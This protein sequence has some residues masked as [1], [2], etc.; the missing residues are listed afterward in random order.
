MVVFSGEPCLLL[1]AYLKK[2]IPWEFQLPE[3]WGP[4]FFCTLG[5]VSFAKFIPKNLYCPSLPVILAQVKGLLGRV[6]GVQS[7]LQTQ[8]VWKPRVRQWFKNAWPPKKNRTLAL[9]NTLRLKLSDMSHLKMDGIAKRSGFLKRGKLG[10]FLGMANCK[11][12]E[13]HMF[14]Q[15]KCGSKLSI[16]N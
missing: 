12:S 6:F 1:G 10:L 14:R 11:F 8:G 5:I 13:V 2:Q 7:Y 4:T 3:F 9:L 15:K 16:K